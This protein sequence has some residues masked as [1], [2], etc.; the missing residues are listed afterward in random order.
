MRNSNTFYL[1][2]NRQESLKPGRHNLKNTISYAS[3]GG[4]FTAP[5]SLS[6]VSEVRQAPAPQRCRLPSCQGELAL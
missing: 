4:G 6:A 5:P 1:M 3:Q 2:Q